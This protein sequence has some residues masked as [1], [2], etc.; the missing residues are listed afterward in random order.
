MRVTDTHIYFFTES[1]PFSNFYP[2]S[3]SYTRIVKSLFGRVIDSID[4]STSEQ[5]YM[6]EKALFFNDI[7]S[8]NN[9]TLAKTPIES[10]NIGKKITNFNQEKWD[11][12][13]FDKMYDICYQKFTKN[14]Y[15]KKVLIESFPKNLVEA[16][17][18]DRRWGVG[19][20]KLDDNILFEYKWLGENRLGNV[21]M[22]VRENI[23]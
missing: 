19:L 20:S 7:K 3:F 9:I 12:V 17:P 4:V 22:K 16:S 23:I 13:S 5:A 10:K 21:L 15:L 14:E 11:Y 1:D 18:F 6:Y 2:V 8:A